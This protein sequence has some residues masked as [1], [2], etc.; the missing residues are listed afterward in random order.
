M[1]GCQLTDDIVRLGFD[2]DEADAGGV[3]VEQ[4]PG[5]FTIAAFN[6]K[7]CELD[8]YHATPKDEF[9]CF[10]SL[11]HS[12]IHQALKNIRAGMKGT[13][14]SIVD[15][16]G[17]YSLVLLRAA[18][19][20]FALVVDTGLLW[21]VLSWKMDVEEPDACSIVQAVMKAKGAL[22]ML[23]HV[24]ATAEPKAADA[25][26]QA[27]KAPEAAKE[28]SK[29]AVAAPEAATAAAASRC[30]SAFAEAR[31]GCLAPAIA[32]PTVGGPAVDLDLPLDWDSGSFQDQ[33]QQTRI[34]AA[35]TRRA[36]WHSPQEPRRATAQL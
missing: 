14:K 2:R 32:E 15:Q 21:E 22:F 27:V 23:Q 28:V 35:S 9:I 6:L 11:S 25:L 13:T 24:A 26:P 31:A 20:T 34:V 17:N 19:P 16:N 29:A 7:A 4:K 36:S 8:L 30:A 10:G 12:H 5:T 33:V 18:D 3:C 1:S